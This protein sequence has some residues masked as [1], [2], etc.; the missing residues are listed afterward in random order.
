VAL[1]VATLERHRLPM[2]DGRAREQRVAELQTAPAIF[3]RH[4][5]R[6]HVQ[7]A[8]E[9]RRLVFALPRHRP[10]HFVQSHEVESAQHAGNSVEVVNAVGA[11]TAV[12]VVR[13]DPQRRRFGHSHGRSD[14]VHRQRSGR[15]TERI[16]MRQV[17]QPGDDDQRDPDS[18]RMASP[19]SPRRCGERR[20]RDDRSRRVRRGRRSH[21]FAIVSKLS[22]RM[23]HADRR[24]NA[25]SAS[26]SLASD[27]ASTSSTV[28]SV[29]H[30]AGSYF[31]GQC[32]AKHG[33]HERFFVSTTASAA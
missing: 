26:S 29:M 20:R 15:G 13:S 5:Q 11:A 2:I 4:V 33:A 32:R 23:A 8:T 22:G 9:R 14:D 25:C 24:R 31:N 10:V 1:A 16:A 6:R 19:S 27:A 7:R 3:G 28:M 21:R 18:P 12:D 30:F 17:P